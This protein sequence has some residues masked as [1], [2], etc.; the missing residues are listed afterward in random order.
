METRRLSPHNYRLDHENF[1]EV[2][3][4][5][6]EKAKITKF[7]AETMS[8]LTMAETASVEPVSGGSGKIA[9][10]FPDPFE[11]PAPPEDEG[12][13]APGIPIFYHCRPGCYSED[14]P[15]EMPNGALRGASKAFQPDDEVIVMQ[16]NRQD[17]Y[18]IGHA[19][20]KPRNCT[21]II[22]IAFP[23]NAKVK[24]FGYGITDVH[25][26]HFRATDQVKYCEVDAQCLDPYG[27]DLK[28][29]KEQ[30]RLFGDMEYYWG[31]FLF[32][33]P[34]YWGEWFIH[35][36]PRAYLFMV[37]AKG[38]L[39]PLGAWNFWVSA[40]CRVYA[41]LY[42]KELE[43]QCIAYGQQKQ[44][45]HTSYWIGQEIPQDPYPGFEDAQPVFAQTMNGL[46]G[47]G[48]QYLQTR[49]LYAKFFAQEWPED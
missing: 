41:A 12:E 1:G 27:N 48:K 43:E 36:G 46:F 20:H 4:V 16:V 3:D 19:D 15:E 14:I 10:E 44:A 35:L 17:K 40:V 30:K 7:Q 22:Q 25:Q 23:R 42:T 34:V 26:V 24:P 9:F 13:E 6:Y 28:C 32:G 47:T 5:T 21:D 18:I 2:Y 29:T 45:A 33:Q 8:P 49:W 39:M 31:D 11:P 37:A 38:F